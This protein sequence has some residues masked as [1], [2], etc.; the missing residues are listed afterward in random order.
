MLR[1]LFFENNP[2]SSSHKP[3]PPFLPWAH[4]GGGDAFQGVDGFV[5][6][7]DA[8]DGGQHEV[9]DAAGPAGVEE[10][11]RLIHIAALDEVC[12]LLRSENL[13]QFVELSADR[14]AADFCLLHSRCIEDGDGL[15]RV[16]VPFHLFE[17]AARFARDSDD[18][19]GECGRRAAEDHLLQFFEDEMPEP[20][21]D[22]AAC[23]PEEQNQAAEDLLIGEVVDE[24]DERRAD[25]TGVDDVGDIAHAFLRSREGESASCGKGEE[26]E[27]GDGDD[28]FQIIDEGNITRENPPHA[29]EVRQRVG[30]NEKNDVGCE[31]ES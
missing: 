8:E 24:G 11:E 9:R 7:D 16:A 18:E 2:R 5:A 20:D 15:E 17:Q 27:R 31:P 3:L 29:E 23:K 26:P 30:R 13:F 6:L 10:V 1:I 25:D 12:D 28:H 22:R 21:C 14:D 4:D 19:R